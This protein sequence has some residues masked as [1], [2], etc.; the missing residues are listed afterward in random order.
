[1]N[2]LFVGFNFPPKKIGGVSIYTNN[3]M[4]ELS[5]RGHEVSYFFSEK[6]NFRIKPYLKIFEKKSIH[7]IQLINSP[8]SYPPN[9]NKTK[10]EISN[11]A[12]EYFFQKTLK[13]CRPDVTHF[14]DFF[15]MSS[16]LI[17]I[18]R[19]YGSIVLT[20]LQ[21]YYPICPSF[22]LF[23]RRKNTICEKFICENC[24]VKDL[25]NN[26]SLNNA[27]F[28]K[29]RKSFSNAINNAHLNL[30]ISKKVKEIY[31]QKLNINPSKILINHLGSR[32]SEFISFNNHWSNNKSLITFIFLG[33]LVP[34]KG[35]PNLLEAFKLIDQSK[36]KLLVYADLSEDGWKKKAHKLEMKFNIEFRDKYRYEELDKILHQADV[37]IVPPIWHDN[38]PQVVLEMFSAGLPIIGSNVGGIP[39]FV[40]HNVNGFLFQ[41]DD[42]DDLKNKMLNFITNPSLI[43]CFKKNIPKIKNM[44]NHATEIESIYFK[45]IKKYSLTS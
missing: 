25:F 21:N 9:F 42:V 24:L 15:G 39:D 19:E 3:L 32:S 16:N 37:G 35:F 31:V 41:Y 10:N 33:R 38:A 12:I 2:V 34:K 14:Q 40:K 26:K 18:A 13:I 8:L 30:A 45:L 36:A 22:N 44:E 23:D 11:P 17:T 28:L 27:F 29:R 1:M 43:D 20:S 5:K 7:Y 6:Q 4:D